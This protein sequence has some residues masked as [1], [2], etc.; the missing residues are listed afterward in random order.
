MPRLLP[1]GWASWASLGS[2]AFVT[3]LLVGARTSEAGATSEG[4]LSPTADVAASFWNRNP[5]SS[6]ISQVLSD[7]SCQLSDASYIS[8]STGGASFLVRISPGATHNGKKVSS[9]DVAV[10]FRYG[11]SPGAAFTPQARIDGTVIRGSPLTATSGECQETVQRI[12]LPTAVTKSDNTIVD[13]GAVKSDADTKTVRICSIRVT[14]NYEDE[15]PPPLPAIT[16]SAAD[17][18]LSTPGHQSIDATR[19][20]WDITIDNSA[21]GAI[22]RQGI[23]V[24]DG[25]NDAVLESTTPA[26]A[27]GSEPSQGPTWTCDVAAGA[28]TVLRVSRPRS[29]VANPCTGGE[30]T[31][32]LASATLVDGTP[33]PIQQG[34]VDSP[35][36]ITVPPD[37]S[38]CPLPTVRL[39]AHDPPVANGFASWDIAIEQPT[40][41]V[42]RAVSILPSTAVELVT[43]APSGACT[44]DQGALACS[45]PATGTVSVTV[46]RSVSAENLDSGSLCNGGII[47]LHLASASL[48]D[49]TSLSITEG[50]PSAPVAYPVQDTSAC[51]PVAVAKSLLP[52]GAAAVAEPDK[53][54]WA[55]SLAN[56]ATGLDG[57][58]IGFR[59]TDAAVVSGPVYST[60]DGYCTGDITSAAGASC[61]LPAGVSVQWT[62]RPSSA[63]KQE[64]AAHTF[65]NVAGYRSRAD[66]PWVELPGPSIVLAGD[67]ALCTRVVEVCLV[68]EDN[69]DGVVEPDGG[70]FRFG[71]SGNGTTLTLEAT[72]GTASCGDLVVP[73]PT[74]SIFQFGAGTGDRPGS[75]GLAGRWSGDAPG[76]PRSFA[77]ES[78]C[79]AAS[80]AE[81]VPVGATVARVTFCNRPAPRTRSIVVAHHYFP[82]ELPVTRPAIAF[83]S[84]HILPSCTAADASD[85]SSSTWTCL[86][87]VDWSGQVNVLV[88]AGRV[89]GACA[90]GLQPAAD[91]RSCSYRRAALM[92]RANFVEHG[93]PL[94]QGDIP[95]VGVDGSFVAP[96][97]VAGGFGWG[98]VAVDPLVAH[99]VDIGFDS[100]RWRLSGEP[101]LEGDACA[102]H[103]PPAKGTA[104]VLVDLPPGGG[105]TVSFTLERLVVT[106]TIHQLYLGAPG[107]PPAFSVAVDGVADG[108]PWA[109]SGSPAH[110]WHKAVV[111]AS[112]GSSLAVTAA[113]PTG[114]AHVAAFRGECSIFN[115]SADPSADDTVAIEVSG[116]QPG[117]EVHICFVSVAVGSLLL[118]VNETRPSAAAEEWQFATT[119]PVV[120]NPALTTAPNPGPDP[121]VTTAVQTFARVPVGSYAIRQLGGSMACQAGATAADFQ[122]TAA[123]KLDAL[124]PDA[125]T[126]AVVG[127]ADVPF[128]IGK[129]RVTYVRFDNAGCGTV[130]ETG[131]IAVAVLND[132]DGDGVRDPGEAG[133]AGWPIEVSGPDGAVELPTDSTGTVQFPVVA[134]GTYEVRE[135]ALPGWRATSPVQITVAAGLGETRHAV[136]FQQPRVAVSAT[137]TE[138]SLAHPAGSPGEGWEVLLAGCGEVRTAATGKAGNVTFED[139]APAVGCEYTVSPGAR[140]GWSFVVSSKTAAPAG[141]GEMA[142]LVF[143]AVKIEVCV[144]C[145]PPAGDGRD[146][147]ESPA[148]VVLRVLPGSNLVT[149]PGGLTPVEQAFGEAHGV[150]AV[151]RWDSETGRWSK[152]FPGLPGYLSDL[153][154]LVPGA[155]YWVIS[156]SGGVLQIP[157]AG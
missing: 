25:N 6:T 84:P 67:P 63:V 68:V 126:T 54:A 120:G 8:S 139:L 136:F 137:L 23:V 12:T 147:E 102:W 10:C 119:S 39:V 149:W 110:T 9:L 124:P 49:G 61:T 105:C 157:G 4:P 47:S 115:G 26:G 135:G 142:T 101:S 107:D 72:E 93:V 3:V 19:A 40:G 83:S 60:G 132:L 81:A 70:Q 152:Y 116:V 114:W 51:G 56:P 87:P 130:L 74:A 104:G 133:V 151:Y 16:K 88:P 66:D 106:V 141:P 112:G 33:L 127:D 77:G 99:A 21:A 64:C 2:A 48:G 80:A 128:D 18:D 156:A 46:R 91:Y 29:A 85:G 145:A 138:I 103:T 154:D 134:G 123:A 153:Q 55:L 140:T 150:R 15:V 31:N 24:S 78:S 43:P 53:V 11:A 79:D 5:T 97:P 27:C 155:A 121:T 13:V 131:V 90:A 122:T 50:G 113:V 95:P 52:G 98:P 65:E 62:V 146:G 37:T 20:Y 76:Y 143:T 108:A 109:E 100:G 73:A 94:D 28:T 82:P 71:N 38:A 59:D 89:A 148:M 36:A 144:A 75:N 117:E 86:V 22:A 7:G 17:L 129:G 96:S 34:T 118:V 42:A 41:G 30:L 35:V 92:V 32:V 111:I 69:H 57:A 45:V 125:G 44:F 1:G 14:I 58:T